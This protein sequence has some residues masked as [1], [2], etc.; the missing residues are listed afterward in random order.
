MK[1]KGLHLADVAEIEEAVTDELTRVQKE[2]LSTAFQKLYD[3]AKACVY[4]SGAYFE[5]KKKYASSSC[6]LDLK[7][8]VLKHLD[9]TVYIRQI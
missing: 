5:F 3:R 7:K 6:V 9:R 2:E 8:S 1:V 4:T